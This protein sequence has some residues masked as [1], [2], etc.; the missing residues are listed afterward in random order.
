MSDTLPMLGAYPVEVIDRILDDWQAPSP[1]TVIPIADE[2]ERRGGEKAAPMIRYRTALEIAA[3]TSEQPDWLVRGFL[4][5]GAITEVDGKVKASGKT[6]LATHLVAAVLDGEPFLG[7]PTMRTKVVYI[8][9]QQAGSFR[10]ALARAGLLARGD[11]M[12]IVLRGDVSGMAWPQLIATAT[13][14]AIRDGYG[15]IVVDTFGKLAGIRDENDAGA[16]AGAMAPLQDAAH[17]GVAVLVTRHDRKGGGDVGESGRG[18]S[19]ISGDVDVILALRRPEGNQ[20]RTRRVIET[21]SRYSET[22]EKVVIELTDEGY[23]LLG[24]A[25]AVSLADGIKFVSGLIGRENDQKPSGLTMDEILNE[26][27]GALDR[28]AIRRALRELE[29]S[30]EMEVT[31][32]GVKGDPKHYRRPEIDSGLTHGVI[33]QNRIIGPDS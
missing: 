1:A 21:L 8:S 31:G 19:A 7:M 10:E 5:L 30:G 17:A 11:E 24:D 22:P 3:S 6:T 15:L 23:I 9:E 20:P 27:D 16:G 4:A 28:S 13:A 29:R 12:R 2:R 33:D 25:E 26:A 32:R 14:D 18:S